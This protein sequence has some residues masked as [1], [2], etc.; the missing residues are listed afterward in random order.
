MKEVTIIDCFKLAIDQ[1]Y[2]LIRIW[3]DEIDCF[4]FNQIKG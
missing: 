4:D 1:D 3:E 2:K